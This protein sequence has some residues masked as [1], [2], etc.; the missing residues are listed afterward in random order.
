MTKLSGGRIRRGVGLL[1]NALAQTLKQRLSDCFREQARSHSGH[2]TD[3]Q[4][5]KAC[6][7]Q[8]TLKRPMMALTRLLA[9]SN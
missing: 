9:S 7:D 8:R 2:L 4:P 3:R 1:E 6:S 5:V